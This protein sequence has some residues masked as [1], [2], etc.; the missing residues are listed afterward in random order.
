M[1]KRGPS[2][3][4]LLQTNAELLRIIVELRAENEHLKAR[5]AKLEKNSANSSKSPSSD[6]VKPS[7]Q[8]G[9]KGNNRKKRKIG[10]QKGHERH[11]SPLRS[12]DA[13]E[14]VK[15]ESQICPDCGGVN[16]EEATERD[17]HFLQYELV[18]NPVI[19]TDYVKKGY[20]CPDC[21]GFHNAEVSEGLEN[22]GITGPRL[23]ALTGFLKGGCH[24]SYSVVGE[25][26]NDVLGVKLASGTIPKIIGRV[27]SALAAS[28][29]ELEN[30]TKGQP[31]LNIDETGFKEN[32]KKLWIWVFKAAQT[33][34][35]KVA[36]SRGS[37]VLVET[38]GE[39]YEGIVG[40]D[41]YGAYRKF[42]KDAGGI[43]IQFCLAHLIRELR[44][45]KE[46][47]GRGAVRYANRLLEILKKVFAVYH[48]RGSTSESAYRRRMNR[49]KEEFLRIGSTSGAK[50]VGAMVKRLMKYGENYFVEALPKLWFFWKSLWSVFDNDR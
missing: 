40:S 19:L 27:S 43:D 8:P 46:K 11:E 6:I 4:E 12:E 32:G 36:D 1:F 9:K 20:Y 39:D 21:G 49:L 29:E 31:H 48:N 7:R 38:L 22:S 14:R 26:L 47:G 44:F 35:F 10:G 37:K 24:A 17:K 42:I 3:K 30:A 45:F 28:Y 13:D 25:F 5:I 16:I 41:F 18:T 15:C 2:R 33:A 50:G 34:L 23:S